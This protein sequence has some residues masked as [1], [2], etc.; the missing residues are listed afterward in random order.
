LKIIDIF[1]AY[2][3]SG[4]KKRLGRGR[5]GYGKA[6]CFRMT[7]ESFIFPK[8][9]RPLPMNEQLV[10]SLSSGAHHYLSRL[11]GT[12]E[13]TTQTWFEPGPPTDESPIRGTMRPLLD[14]RFILHE[15]TSRVGDQPCQGMA[16][17]GYQLGMNSFQS[18]W[19][20]S[21]HTGTAMLFSEGKKGQDTFDV[22][23][24]YAYVTPETEQ[25]WGWRT[26]L[27]LIGDDELRITAYNIS[28]EGEEDK[29]TETRYRRVSSSV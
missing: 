13:G 14:G 24:S 23:G 16:I 7:P 1:L 25:F 17:F 19:L 18:I 27:E 6:W 12:W 21:F 8:T 2:G 11:A 4:G 10:S 15:Y 3:K 28:P 20:D 22:L 29:A 26:E 5:S 9:D